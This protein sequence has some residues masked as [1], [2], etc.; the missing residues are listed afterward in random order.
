MGDAVDFSRF[1]KVPRFDYVNVC[2]PFRSGKTSYIRAIQQ[3]NEELDQDLPLD[4]YR[5]KHFLILMDFSDYSAKT[6]DEAICFFKKKMSDLFVA[7]YDRI[8]G[9]LDN[10]QI[11][12]WYL[13]VEEGRCSEEKLRH[14]LLDLVKTVRY[15]KNW[16]QYYYRPLIIIDEVSRPILYASKYGYLD[17]LLNFYDEYLDIDH[18]EM[19][20][21]II[22][23]SY[24]PANTDVPYRLKYIGN[25][26][27]NEIEPLNTICKMN[28]IGLVERS[29]SSCYGND[30]YFDES[31][32]LERCFEKMMLESDFDEVTDYNYDINLPKEINS[33]INR[34][35]IWID[36]QKFNMEE[37]KKRKKERER[38]EY[39][40]PLAWG[41]NIPSKY[42]GIRELDCSNVCSDQKIPLNEKLND[43]YTKY[44]QTAD[45]KTIYKDIQH[46]GGF[47][48]NVDEIR[49]VVS[50]LKVYAD[51]YSSTNNCHIDVDDEYWA[52]IDVRK[53]NAY[54]SDMSLVKVYVSVKE[55]K[56]IQSIFECVVRYLIEECKDLFHAK[57]SVRERH[58]HICLWISK[59]VFLK[60]EKYLMR[61]DE[62]LY[63]P[64]DFVPYRGKLGITREF[65]SWSSY[66]GLLSELI[67]AYL[68]SAR[69]I[70]DI[71]VL[72]MYFKYVKAWNGDY[73]DENSLFG[74]FKASNAQELIILLESLDVIVGNSAIN[75]D[76]I[77]LN[78]DSKMWCALGES[79]NWHDVG[80]RMKRI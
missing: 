55:Q 70:D 24:A 6:Y 75:D 37:S 9:E 62:V 71:D 46:I 79:K 52:K 51:T 56:D 22:T 28:S 50:K 34:K 32:S 10:Y 64:L 36:V 16:N 66:N 4:D 43:F 39:A 23:T 53:D 35:R 48:K 42:A 61:F 72:D 47:Y 21:G 31:V 19:T 17:G 77:L 13:D 65:F 15:G 7:I 29:K 40:E 59:E 41:V 26:P 18:Y 45:S 3:Y 33:A 25:K 27:V 76:N 12:E 78:C 1:I 8:K 63:T 30:Q 20:A 5:D 74:R 67:V 11:L 57:V 2:G 44:G 14:G 54:L 49:S 69:S 68:S 80:V 58:D 60:L 73:V 38:R